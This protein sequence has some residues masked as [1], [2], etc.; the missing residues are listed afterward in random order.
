M[1]YSVLCYAASWKYCTC[2]C[3]LGQMPANGLYLAIFILMAFP[4]FVM[5]HWEAPN[6]ELYSYTLGC[7]DILGVDASTCKGE[8]AVYRICTGTS[9]WF[10]LACHCHAFFINFAHENLWLSKMC[11][12]MRARH[13]SFLCAYTWSKWLHSMRVSYPRHFSSQIVS[14]IDLWRTLGTI[15]LQIKARSILYWVYARRRLWPL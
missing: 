5:Q 12:F 2:K 4:A 11:C 10:F 8:Q 3:T 14:F 15:I 7:K 6:I 1:G 9:V 13:G